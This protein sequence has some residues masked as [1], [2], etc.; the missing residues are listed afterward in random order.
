VNIKLILNILSSINGGLITGAALFNPLVGQSNALLII[1]G[2]GICQIV[3]SAVNSN[4]STQS[5]TVAGVAAILGDDGR[6]A[7][8]VNVNPNAPQNLVAMA[9]DPAQPNVG[10]ASPDVRATLQAVAKAAS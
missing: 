3:V 10:A 9:I 7:V 5:N 6:P 2:L 4:L 8:R 1:S